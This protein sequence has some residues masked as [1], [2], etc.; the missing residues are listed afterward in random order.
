MQYL[1]RFARNAVFGLGILAGCKT[2]TEYKGFDERPNGATLFV[3]PLSV[4]YA[5]I[6]NGCTLAIV[7][8]IGKKRVSVVYDSDDLSKCQKNVTEAA[9][10]IKTAINENKPVYF[11]TDE[12]GVLTS[13]SASGLTAP[14][15]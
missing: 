11:S 8:D 12:N 7:A 15:D 1:G 14:L 4:E 13:V 10:I 2:T 9:A 5:V 3:K 6:P